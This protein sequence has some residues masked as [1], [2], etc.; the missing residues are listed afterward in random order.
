MIDYFRAIMARL[1]GLFGDH[2]A[3]QELDDEIEEHIRLLIERYL[4]QGMKDTEAVWAAR[5]Q[6]GN[7]TLLREVNSEMRGIR[8]IETLFQD[9]R[10]GL[11]MMKK[12]PGFTLVAALTLSLGIGANT[13]IFGVVN[14][15]LLRP[16]PFK[17]PERLVMVFDR[18]AEA[19]GGDRT[20]LGV[21][22]LF[23]LREQSRSFTGIEAFEGGLYNYTGGESPERI[24][25]FVVTAKFFSTLGVQPQ[26][27]RDFS[28]DEERPG[29]QRV[30]LISDSFWRTHFA[31]DP[32]V[33]GRPINLSGE[34]YNVIGVMPAKLDFP[35]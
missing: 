25:G 35:N 31:A 12:N 1:R 18:E 28:P 33:L 7:V 26:I 20:P 32:Q 29:A 13:A 8:F 16:L 15:I 19:A 5:R 34:S 24:L 14:A 3:D 11:W 10:Y 4:S 22:D 6:F 17:D 2:R 27:G 30:A 21:S 9:V 23:D